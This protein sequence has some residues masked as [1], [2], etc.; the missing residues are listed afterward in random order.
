MSFEQ[1][2]D[3]LRCDHCNCRADE[4]REDRIGELARNRGEHL[5]SICIWRVVEAEHDA[6]T[7]DPATGL[8]FI[9]VRD[10]RYRRD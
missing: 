3:G 2:G 1:P 9:Q 5:C 4:T 10:E 6:A 8:R 7:I